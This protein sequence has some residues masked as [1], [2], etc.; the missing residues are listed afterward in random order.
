MSRNIYYAVVQAG[1]DA[2]KPRE[3]IGWANIEVPEGRE[4]VLMSNM[5]D[6]HWPPAQQDMAPKALENGKIVPFTPPVYTAPLPDQA[7]AA[8]NGV[9]QKATMVAAM[10]E[11]F[12]PRMRTYVQALRAIANGSDTT[13]TELPTAPDD[14]T[15]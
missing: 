8:L 3:I 14:V 1:Q 10:G 6:A 5:D 2:N 13:S 4:Y 11:E 7:N 15:A 9:Q 12:D